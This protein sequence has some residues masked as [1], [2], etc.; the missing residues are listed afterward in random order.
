MDLGVVKRQDDAQRRDDPGR[1]AVRAGAI[2][3]RLVDV[4][5]HDG[6]LDAGRFAQ[7]PDIVR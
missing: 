7:Q 4:G 2:D 5:L 6:E 3:E 1:L